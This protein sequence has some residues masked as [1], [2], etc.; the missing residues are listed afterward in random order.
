MSVNGRKRVSFETGKLANKQL[1]T[2]ILDYDDMPP[3]YV[4][5]ASPFIVHDPDTFQPYM[6]FTAW[7]D[8][9]AR[10][11]EVWV[12]RINEDLDVSD[13]RQ[14]A[15]GDLFGV[16]GFSSATAFWDDYNE[17][18][19]FATTA[20]GRAKKSYGHFIFFDRDW[21]VEDT[22]VIDFESTFNT[23]TYTPD[24][25]DA[26]IGMVPSSVKR[27]I[28]SVGFH[29]DRSLYYINDL[30]SRP[31][32]DPTYANTSGG[33][34]F[35]AASTYRKGSIGIHQLFAYND[36]LIMLSEIDSYTRG[37]GVIPHFG[38]E[39]EWNEVF[40]D[41][42]VG[43]FHM[44]CPVTWY[45][46]VQN[47]THMIPNQMMMPHY[48]TVLGTPLL[49]FACS[50]AWNLGGTRRYRHEVW[51]QTIDP[52]KAFDPTKN[53]PLVA[54]GTSSI[55]YDIG[56]VPIPT[57]GAST[58]CIEI[59][60]ADSSGTLT[61]IES[62]SPYRIWQEGKFRYSDALSIGSGSSKNIINRPAPYMAIK[63]DVSM[64]G[65]IITLQGG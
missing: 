21:N 34:D 47:Y 54:R 59:H 10:K 52:S 60:G 41:V 7:Q 20:Y 1:V 56:K 44:P 26:G 14:I 4:G 57:F 29:S 51:A 16:D 5:V 31:L 8:L 25:G 30:T 65:W 49:F 9:D 35:L 48:T 33:N 38:P 17:Q 39:K 55:P 11:R 12:A 63:T 58:A 3:G 43:K 42:M 27:L 23:T 64:D 18:W 46:G 15:T 2:R 13:K 6:L 37:W 22:Q 53:F 32:P 19:V 62:P 61:V 50:P 40:G 36:I 28:L 45:Y 24:L